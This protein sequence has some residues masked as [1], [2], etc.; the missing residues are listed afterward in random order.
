MPFQ[1]LNYK[2]K[3]ISELNL[4]TDK[5]VSLFGKVVELK[6]NSF[7]LSDGSGNIE[8]FS[9]LPIESMRLVRVFCSV[10]ENQLR[11]DT[12][13]SLNG[14]DADLFN[15]IEELYKARGL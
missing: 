6:G 15:R 5:K 10:V 13:Q 1:S 2:P 8:I 11:A 3:K 4:K 12:V 7:V 9:D 14:F